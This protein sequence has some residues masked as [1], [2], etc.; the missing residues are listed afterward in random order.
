MPL[1]ILAFMQML[2]CQ[3]LKNFIAH[4]LFNTSRINSRICFDKQHADLV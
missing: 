2:I 1:I 3:N 4:A